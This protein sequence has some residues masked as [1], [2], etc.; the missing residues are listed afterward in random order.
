MNR[1]PA[2]SRRALPAGI[3]VAIL[4]ASLVPLPEK[5]G[6][7]AVVPFGI[8]AWL[9]VGGYAALAASLLG[10]FRFPDTS[11]SSVQNTSL[12]VVA[13]MVFGIGIEIA[14]TAVPGRAFA[15]GDIL[16]NAIGVTTGVVL[17]LAVL[18]VHR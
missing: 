3:A 2:Y 11:G 4:C 7:P 8:T 6:G 16:A 14:Q 10:V 5:R 13:T 1:P 9:H 18:T 12:T 17:A 15:V